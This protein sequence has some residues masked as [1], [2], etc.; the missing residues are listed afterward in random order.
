MFCLESVVFFCSKNDKHMPS[1]DPNVE[2]TYTKHEDADKLYGCSMSEFYHTKITN[3]LIVLSWPQYS[4]HQM[5]L[6]LIYIYCR[7]RPSLS[8]GTAQQIVTN[9][10]QL[11]IP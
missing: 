1:Y 4:I 7:G 6:K 8:G 10:H 9:F 3:L 2:S 11:Q 5:K